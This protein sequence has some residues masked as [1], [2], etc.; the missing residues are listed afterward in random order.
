[1]KQLRF[2]FQECAKRKK[3]TTWVFI[4]QELE[5]LRI[6]HGFTL[7]K[8]CEMIFGRGVLRCLSHVLLQHRNEN[9][10]F[11]LCDQIIGNHIKL[12]QDEIPIMINEIKLAIHAYAQYVGDCYKM[13]IKKGLHAK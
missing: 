9:A 7:V 12:Q 6:V 8:L 1:M 10:A 4:M 11:N 3:Y 5:R 13:S 2:V